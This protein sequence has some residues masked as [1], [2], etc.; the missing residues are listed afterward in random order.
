MANELTIS[1]SA[2]YE[3]NNHELSFSPPAIQVTVAG[4]QSSGA[5]VEATTTPAGVAIDVTELGAA[6]QGWAWFRNI[7]TDSATHIAV[8]PRDGSGNFIECFHLLGGEFAIMRVGDQQLYCKSS[9]GTLNLQYNV[10]EA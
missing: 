8:G 1:A 10:L 9:S 5:V 6:A 7:G 2:S 4:D 3:K